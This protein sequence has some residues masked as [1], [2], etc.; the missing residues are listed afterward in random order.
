MRDA[1]KLG[2]MQF[3]SYLIITISW[4]AIAQANVPAAALS[5][6][7]FGSLQFFV[8]RRIAKSDGTSLVPWI[9]YTLGGVVGT[10]AGIYLSLWWFGK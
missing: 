10:V 4:R 2:A 9:G 8:L 6:A 1:L 5:D 7:V 3:A